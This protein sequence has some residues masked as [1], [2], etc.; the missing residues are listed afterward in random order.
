MSKILLCF[1][2]SLQRQSSKPK[3]DIGEKHFSMNSK[4]FHAAQEAIFSNKIRQTNA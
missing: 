1:V 4:L 3:Q 2:S